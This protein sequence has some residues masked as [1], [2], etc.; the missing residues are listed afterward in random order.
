MKEQV[1][2]I[3]FGFKEAG[4]S[5]QKVEQ[6]LGF[7]NGSLGKVISG[8]AGLSEF[9]F[10]KLL[11]LHKDKIGKEISPTKELEKQIEENNKPEN[12]KRI[13]K[14]REGSKTT[15][16]P[17]WDRENGESWLDFRVRESDWIE[18]QNKQ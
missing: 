14:N 12:K 18:N 17:V 13:L 11:E 6:E 9:R 3:L 1:K 16:K 4:W 2:S 10:G 15:A 8:K 5:V 7:S